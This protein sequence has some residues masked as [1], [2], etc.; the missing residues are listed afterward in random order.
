[1][2]TARFLST[3]LLLSALVPGPAPAAPPWDQEQVVD[4]VRE[5]GERLTTLLDAL[6]ELETGPGVDALRQAFTQDVVDAHK[7]ATALLEQLE[8][9]A[10]RAATADSQRALAQVASR[11]LG[12]IREARPGAGADALLQPVGALLWKLDRFYAEE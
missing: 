6:K 1:M 7:Q 9:G 8:G 5:L 2:R 11:A 4:T 10:G 12:K 3:L